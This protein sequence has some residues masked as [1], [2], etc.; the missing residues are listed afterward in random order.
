VG[1]TASVTSPGRL[2]DELFSNRGGGTLILPGERI[3]R[4]DSLEGLDLDN[5]RNLLEASFRAKLPASYFSDL[6]KRLHCVLLAESGRG[7][8]I[9]TREAGLIDVPYLDKFAVH[10]SAQGEQL[11]E[12]VWRSLCASCPSFYWRS[13]TE[14]PVNG[15]YFTQA[16]GSYRGQTG[17]P[18]FTV[19]W[20]NLQDDDTVMRAVR[21]ALSLPSTFVR[22][23]DQAPLQEVPATPL[24]TGVRIAQQLQQERQL[25]QQ[26]QQLARA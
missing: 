16:D 26:Q 22:T 8:A 13:R 11:G 5:L 3:Q 21:T 23:N 2:A 24:P 10:P 9:V 15:W 17:T 18:K 20:R 12:A 6:S 19:F 14:N 1:S 25:Q 7:A 4:F